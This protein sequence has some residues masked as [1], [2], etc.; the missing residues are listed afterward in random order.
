M[1]FSLAKSVGCMTFK[2]TNDFQRNFGKHLV[3]LYEKIGKEE[4]MERLK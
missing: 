4:F 3:G 2:E 1:L